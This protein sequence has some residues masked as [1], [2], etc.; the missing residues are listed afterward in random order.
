M[1]KKKEK[2]KI[3]LFSH[4]YYE[5]TIELAN[6]LSRLAE[7]YLFLPPDAAK[8][9]SS[10]EKNIKLNLFKKNRLRSLKN[11]SDMFKLIKKF[12]QI[13]PDVIHFQDN[14]F[15]LSLFPQ[16]NRYNIV[17]TQHD[18]VLHIGEKK[19]YDLI[20][21]NI[22]RKISKRIIVHGSYLKKLM[23]DKYGTNDETIKIIPHGNLLF[24]RKFKKKDIEE[25]NN[26]ILFFG[27]ICEYKGLEYLIESMPLIEKEIPNVK[28]I[29]AGQGDCLE[30]Y[31]KKIENQELF[32]I[33]NRYIS[34]NEI[35]E[36]F[37][38]SSIVI[39]PYIEAS[40]SGVIPIA[41]AFGK[42]VIA[43]N[44]GSLA[45]MVDNGK[46]GIV[47]PPKDIYSIVNSIILLL[48]S[49]RTRRTM[50]K[51]AERKN[52]AELSWESIS[53]KTLEVYKECTNG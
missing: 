8:Y 41:Y 13:S 25:E 34:N 18:P 51:N 17:T 12:N 3:I 6:A 48:K 49:K 7:I 22:M 46:T 11:I 37:Q 39:L 35:P 1:N 36:L 24:Y 14:Y 43:T 19:I 50:G 21:N 31:K 28:L 4:W 15:W 16:L 32:E 52:K 38:R 2:L 30:K 40:Q 33:H 10:I 23:I 26:T 27:R 29:I 5:Y 45:E 9:K 53:K 42:P 44:V 47:I 20:T